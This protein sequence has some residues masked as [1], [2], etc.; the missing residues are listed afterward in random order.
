MAHLM[1]RGPSLSDDRRGQLF[2]IGALMLAIAFVALTMLLNTAIY[3]ENMAAR[4]ETVGGTDI[5]EF[6]N[7]AHTQAE[8][9]MGYANYRSDA[10]SKETAFIRMSNDWD[11]LLKEE[12]GSRGILARV[13]VVATTPGEWGAQTE[14]ANYSAHHNE[15]NNDSRWHVI[16][17]TSDVRNFTVTPYVDSLNTS[18]GEALTVEFEEDGGG[19][20]GDVYIYQDSP[21]T[22]QVD[23]VLVDGTTAS[24]TAEE[25]AD[26]TVTVDITRATAGGED[27]SALEL[28]FPIDGQFNVFYDNVDSGEGYWHATIPDS[29]WFGTGQ[30]GV[31]IDTAD[32]YER[33]PNAIYSAT[34]AV[35]YVDSERTYKEAHRVAPGEPER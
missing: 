1:T 5:A 3:T 34:V 35:T 18:S 9:M 13:G 29:G 4:G 19:H 30:G 33:E 23:V 16:Q 8:E 27:C 22:A 7:D 20:I 12:Y 6:V 21:D 32:E 26:G 10:S 14:R 31:E 28:L 24:C 2:L 15:Q 25:A 11:E 17:S